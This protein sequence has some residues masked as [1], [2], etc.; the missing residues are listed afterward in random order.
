MRANQALS[1]IAG[2]FLCQGKVCHLIKHGEREKVARVSAVVSLSPLPGMAT[3]LFREWKV[4]SAFDKMREVPHV[5][6]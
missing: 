5:G 4:V 6:V 1:G 2:G 3:I